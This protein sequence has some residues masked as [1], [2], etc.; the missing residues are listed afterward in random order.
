METTRD[1]PSELVI[2]TDS[3]YVINGMDDWILRW[4]PKKAAAAENADLWAKLKAAR[5]ARAGKTTFVYVKGH[6]GDPGNDAADQLA[7]Q[8]AKMNRR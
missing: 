5:E 1:E 6:S 3:A 7:V 4:S 2:H 8:G